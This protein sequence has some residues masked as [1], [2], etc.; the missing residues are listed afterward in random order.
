MSVFSGK[1]LCGN[2]T[3]KCHAEPTVIFNCHCEDCRRA[4]GSVFGTNFFV[5]ED[6]LEIFGEVSSYSHTADSGSAMTKRFCPNCGSLLFGNNSAKS[7]VV[8]I[9]AGTVD[10]L[11]LIK[12]VVNVFMDSK[13]SSTSIDKNLKQASRMPL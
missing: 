3:Y 6:E 2:V 9:R 4:T 1:C 12:P 8:S 7:N 13:V 11:D 10:Q 5:P